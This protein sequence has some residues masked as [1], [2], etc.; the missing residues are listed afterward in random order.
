[1]F[2]FFYFRLFIS[3]FYP[4]ATAVAAA[5]ETLK[6]DAILASARAEAEVWAKGKQQTSAGASYLGGGAAQTTGVSPLEVQAIVAE[7]NQLRQLLREA[8][9]EIRKVGQAQRFRCLQLLMGS[10]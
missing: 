7:R 5:K 1:V 4:A 6:S 3:L 8:E 10:V 9:A 2:L